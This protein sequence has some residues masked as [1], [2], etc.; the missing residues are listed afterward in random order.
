MVDQQQKLPVRKAHR[1]S[2][3]IRLDGFGTDC[4][5]GFLGHRSVSADTRNVLG[6][7]DSLLAAEFWKWVVMILT[8][9][10]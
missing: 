4:H 5:R 8:A 10:S 9:K 7:P 3:E 1:L 2:L 6:K